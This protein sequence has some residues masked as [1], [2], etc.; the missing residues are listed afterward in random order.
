M[1]GIGPSAVRYRSF[2][3]QF[4]EGGVP[5]HRAGGER[6]DAE[7]EPLH[8]APFPSRRDDDGAVHA[9]ADLREHLLRL[10]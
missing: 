9:A 10:R 2:A 1:S 8:A 3:D 5:D 4:G 7:V 6:M